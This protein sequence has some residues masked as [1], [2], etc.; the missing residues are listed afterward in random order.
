M[1]WQALI[2]QLEQEKNREKPFLSFNINYLFIKLV[3]HKR[4]GIKPS[5]IFASKLEAYKGGFASA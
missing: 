1:A 5:L 4:R 3:V 2:I